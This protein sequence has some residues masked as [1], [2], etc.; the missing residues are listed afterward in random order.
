MKKFSNSISERLTARHLKCFEICGN[1]HD[2]SIL[3][4]GPSF[5]WFELMALNSGCSQVIGMEP[6]SD[7][8]YAAQ[9]EVPQAQFIE[10]SALDIPFQD[11]YFDIVVMFDVIEHL[12]RGSESL[13]LNEI[14]RVLKKGGRI[15]LSTPYKHPLSCVFDPAWYFGHRHYS[16]KGLH[17]LTK[18]VGF[19]IGGMEVRGGHYEMISS[20]LMYFFK[21]LF[22]SEIPFKS[23][24]E[25]KKRGEYL[26][27]KDGFETLYLYGTKK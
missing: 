18:N 22:K 21:W 6:K 24:F 2:M 26:G 3:D 5:G 10:G 4:I 16:S 7:N 12:P 27:Q 17:D 13:A 9:I 15:A 23:W 20:L 1:L 25:E 11:E 14:Y 8:F 19:T